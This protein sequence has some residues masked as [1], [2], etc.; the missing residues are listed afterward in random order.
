MTQESIV[1]ENMRQS[2]VLDLMS[3]RE[4]KGKREPGNPVSPPRAF[5]STLTSFY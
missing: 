2:R 3:A 4:Q 1:T 5:L